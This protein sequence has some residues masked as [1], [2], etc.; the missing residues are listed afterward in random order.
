MRDVLKLE[1][2]VEGM[3]ISKRDFDCSTCTMGKMPEFRN[4]QADERA[5]KVLELVH[6]DLPGLITPCSS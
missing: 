3:K 5:S 4:R 2:L 1:N 6:C